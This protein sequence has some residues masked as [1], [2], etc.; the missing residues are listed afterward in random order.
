MQPTGWVDAFVL[1]PASRRMTPIERQPLNR[2]AAGRWLWRAALDR[3]VA[4]IAAQMQHTG[5][6]IELMRAWQGEPPQVI[7]LT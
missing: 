7:Y 6:A 4:L 5:N 2:C 3:D 1:S